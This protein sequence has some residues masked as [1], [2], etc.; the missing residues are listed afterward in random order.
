MNELLN[1]ITPALDTALITVLVA[2][3][4]YLG[5]EIV[6]LVPTIIDFVVAKMGLTNYQKTKLIALDIWNVV[7][8]HFRI[9]EVI[10]DT[11]QSKITMF[12][13]LIKQKIPGISDADIETVRQAIA[14]EV[15]K[16]KVEIIA[17]FEDP[18][19]KVPI[20]PIVKYVT[21]EGVELQ[22][23]VVADTQAAT[24]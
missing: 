14:G 1:Q 5:K 2:F 8:E 7:E 6:K 4:G 9:N 3:I 20:T 24:Q 13:S 17:A 21:P 18:I 11:V 16:D 15:N 19:Q 22:P 12:E 10:G 23:V